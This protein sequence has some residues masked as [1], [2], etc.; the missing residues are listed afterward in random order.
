[1]SEA[2]YIARAGATETAQ[3]RVRLY[4]TQADSFARELSSATD[5]SQRAYLKGMLAKAR[6]NAA[7]NRALLATVPEQVH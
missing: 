6:K 5:D 3:E 2:A 1:M 4:T 7:Y